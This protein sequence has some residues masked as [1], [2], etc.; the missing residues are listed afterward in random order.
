[1][2][3]NKL[4]VL[5]SAAE[6]IAD[7]ATSGDGATDTPASC[8]GGGIMSFL[9]FILIIGVFYFLMI[10]P[11]KKRSKA[12]QDMRNSVAVGN[13]VT[14]IGGI[15]GSVTAVDGDMVTIRSGSTD[16]VV[17]KWAIRSIDA[18]PTAEN[19]TYTD[20]ELDAD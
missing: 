2:L 20:E 19:F 16:V 3:F 1:M 11:E 13:L 8:L 15:T 9:P 10:R 6:S 12:A 14:T 18:A 7:A 5:T 4:M 17:Q